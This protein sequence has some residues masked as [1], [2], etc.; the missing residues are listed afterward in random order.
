MKADLWVSPARYRYGS[1]W[2]FIGRDLS[3][4]AWSREVGVP[5]KGFTLIELLIVV[6]IIAVIA[7]IAVPALLRA[8]ISANEAAAIGDTRTVI[9][10]RGDLS[11]GELR[12]L[13]DDHLP[14][15]PVGAACP[16]T[17]GRASS[18]PSSG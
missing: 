3:N 6:A 12:L 1:K 7:A 4:V 9:S 5:Q 8:R 11:R 17:T 10:A 18:I 15:Q 2:T 16:T 13:R 14:F